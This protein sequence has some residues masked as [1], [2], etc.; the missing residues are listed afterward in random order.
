MA[1]PENPFGKAPLG[2]ATPSLPARRRGRTADST[3]DI[4]AEEAEETQK[5]KR[6]KKPLGNNHTGLKIASVV[7]GAPAVLGAGGLVL[8]ET[9]A[10]IHRLADQ[11]W[12]DLFG[13]KSLTSTDKPSLV[14]DVNIRKGTI[15]PNATQQVSQQEINKLDPFKKIDDHNTVIVVY[16]IDLR[17]SS[18]PNAKHQFEITNND[19]GND[20]DRARLTEEGFLNSIGIDNVPA[21]TIIRAPVDG[22]LHLLANNKLP[23]AE[24]NVESA[25]I[26][27]VL[28]D[29]RVFNL[30][31]SGG[32][33]S[34]GL[35]PGVFKTITK[36]P[37]RTYG[38]SP[39]EVSDIIK[40]GIPVNKGDPILQVIP[41]NV[42]LGLY[43]QGNTDLSKGVERSLPNGEKVLMVKD[44]PTNLEF[45]LSPTGKFIVPAD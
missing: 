30:L 19:S 22:K 44:E 10:P 31:I 38:M 7:I 43:L 28:E 5:Q 1:N 27:F 36:A 24:R 25:Q 26:T 13:G 42:I 37:T 29:G 9:V 45:F 39:R 33:K 2:F 12:L 3:P 21:G 40:Q 20:K 32:I 14:F 15:L 18:N 17:S 23:V 41:N 35:R 11:A 6:D 34:N 16:P 8:Y 4:S